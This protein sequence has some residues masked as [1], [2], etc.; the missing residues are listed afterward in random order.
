MQQFS[1]YFFFIG[2]LFCFSCQQAPRIFPQETPFSIEKRRLADQVLS[3]FENNTTE[4]QY[5][6]AENLH[7]GRGITAGRA[8]FTS[9][10]G[11]MLLVVQYYSHIQPI[12]PLAQYLP[13]LQ[14]LA[15]N[16]DSATVGLENLVQDWNNLGNDSLF[17]AVQDSVVNEL[18]YQPALVYANELGLHTPLG[19]LCLYD[20]IIQHGDG[21]DEDGL[22]AL[23]ERTGTTPKEGCSEDIWIKRFNK[24][25]KKDLCNPA[26]KDTQSEWRESIG[27]VEALSELLSSE[28]FSLTA[29]FEINPYG[30][31]F[32]IQ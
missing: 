32:V 23:I 18:Y 4:I 27:R 20:A 13:V 30:D 12:N 31:S 17:R 26:N 21:D 24:V 2:L 1:K 19:L 15:T 29:P 3:V 6:Y 14:N 22:S 8:G 11:D 16:E 5:G 7:D 25:R 28:N 9:A 10:T